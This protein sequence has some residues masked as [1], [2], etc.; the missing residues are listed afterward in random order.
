LYKL[1]SNDALQ[2]LRTEKETM[3]A[4]QKYKKVL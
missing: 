1:K 4:C 2:P 3:E